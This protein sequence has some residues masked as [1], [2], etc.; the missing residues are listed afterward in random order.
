M[1][2]LVQRLERTEHLKTPVTQV[3]RGEGKEEVDNRA[4]RVF[5]AAGGTPIYRPLMAGETMMCDAHNVLGWTDGIRFSATRFT[6]GSFGGQ[7]CQC[8]CGGE[9]YKIRCLLIDLMYSW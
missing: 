1:S 8:V 6:T 4:S 2:C 5:I 7:L 3:E 9:V